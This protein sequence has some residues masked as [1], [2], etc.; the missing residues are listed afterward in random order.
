MG[1]KIPSECLRLSSPYVQFQ[2]TSAVFWKAEETLF[3]HMWF[4]GHPY[5]NYLRL[6]KI[7]L[8]SLQD[9]ECSLRRLEHFRDCYN[10]L[11][12]AWTSRERTASVSF[13]LCVVEEG[14]TDLLVQL[15]RAVFRC[16]RLWCRQDRRRAYRGHFPNPDLF[17]SLAIKGTSCCSG[18]AVY[19]SGNC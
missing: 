9:Q 4:A 14:N 1:W 17:L 10:M 3:V 15:G 19:N 18:K 11:V 5:W 13:S 8:P 2:N 7:F 12:S 16:A 6:K